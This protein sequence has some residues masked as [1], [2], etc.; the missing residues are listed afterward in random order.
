[1]ILV[2]GV[3]S[4]LVHLFTLRYRVSG[5]RLEIRQ[6]LLN[7]QAR[8]LAPDRIQNVSLVRNLFH[9]ASAGEVRIETA[10]DSSTE[11]MLSALSV[12]DAEAL[13]TELNAARGQAAAAAPPST[14]CARRRRRSCAS[15]PPGAPRLRLYKRRGVG[16]RD[17][18]HG[19]WAARSDRHPP[20]RGETTSPA[21]PP[22]PPRGPRRARHR[23]LVTFSALRAP[24]VITA[25]P[26]TREPTPRG[27]GLRAVE[28]LFTR[29]EV[30]LSLNKVQLVSAVEPL[31]RRLMGYGTVSVETAGFT[32][33]RT[34]LPAA[35][36]SSSR[37]SSKTAWASCS[38]RP[39]PPSPSTLGASF[40]PAHPAPYAAPS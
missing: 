5:G 6:G 7:R 1:M 23:R 20:R 36:G 2:P 19:A 32:A 18:S 4:T 9:R 30:S 31:L 16:P 24:S 38:P 35:A 10:G 37:W 29:R 26:L 33:G 40:H 3:L 11:G 34:G 28:G 17:L 15:A 14:P 13:L 39:S 25:S 27:P 21:P 22:H 8:T 12:E